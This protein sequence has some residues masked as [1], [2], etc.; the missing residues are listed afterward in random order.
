MN[1]AWLIAA[2]IFA[3]SGAQ[4]Q[5]DPLEK[6]AQ[7]QV[8]QQAPGAQRV[9]EILRGAGKKTD[10]QIVL[11]GNTC[12]WF[13]G[14]SEGLKKLY[15]Y[16]W[17]PGA[18]LFTPRL[19]DAKSDGATVMAHC[20]GP[21]GMY[22]LQV[23]TEGNGRYVVSTWAKEAP[24]QVAP[25]PPPAPAPAPAAQA[26]DLGPI[27][28]KTAKVAAPQAK[29][30]G[31]FFEGNG[32]SIGRSD[33]NDY[34]IEMEGGKCYW[35]IGCGEPDKIKSLYLYL[36]GPNNKRITEAKSDSPNPMVGHCAQTTGMFKVQAKVNSGKGSYKVGVYSK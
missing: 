29:R 34:M 20:T 4:A 13:S 30:Q 1:R 27:C 14:T 18:N 7:A 3:A 26:P 8:Q 36:W 16:L 19:T 21:A 6:A 22:K 25:P 9:G 28:D 24:K 35:V 2:L 11:E 12:Y 17:A 10:Y 5:E 32:S 15:M 23:K 33:R 31:E